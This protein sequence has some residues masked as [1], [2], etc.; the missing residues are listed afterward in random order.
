M[1]NVQET[2]EGSTAFGDVELRSDDTRFVASYQT[3]S[4]GFVHLL[5]DYQYSQTGELNE[6]EVY[7]SGYQFPV[8]MAIGQT[9]QLN[10]TDTTTL[11]PSGTPSTRSLTDVVTFVGFEN[12]TLAGHVFANT[13]KFTLPTGTAGQVRAVW[14]AKGFGAIRREWQ[15]TQ[16]VMVA[17]SRVELATIVSAP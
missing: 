5:G 1:L 17:G 14:V 13:C 8:D 9:V 4:G 15:D 3:I 16:G 7:S 12:L 11:L 10:Y 2:F 6:K